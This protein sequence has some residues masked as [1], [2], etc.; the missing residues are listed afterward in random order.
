MMMANRRARRSASDATRPARPAI[1]SP[2]RRSARCSANLAVFGGAVRI[3]LFGWPRLPALPTQLMAGLALLKHM[4]DLSDEALCDCWIE[5]PY[6]QFFCGE[7]F[8]Q[9]RLPFDHSSLTRSRQR[10][11]EAKL[12]ALIRDSLSVA[13]KAAS[14]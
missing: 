1:S 6:F 2:R 14:S 3:G 5:N 11:G 10:T 9:H 12:T 8:F 7:E 13:I 4:C